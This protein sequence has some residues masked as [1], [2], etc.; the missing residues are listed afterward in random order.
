MIAAIDKTITLN[1]LHAELG[2]VVEKWYYIGIQ[3]K[4][5]NKTLNAIRVINNKNTD[6]CMM[7]VCEEWFGQQNKCNKVPEWKTIVDVL[8]SRVISE[9][10][11]ADSLHDKYCSD[12]LAE[13]DEENEPKSKSYTW[14]RMMYYILMQWL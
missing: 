9:S 11:L 3:L 7:R 8:K 10:K 13:S 14:V 5:P 1:K 6:V 4:V 2:P 12:A